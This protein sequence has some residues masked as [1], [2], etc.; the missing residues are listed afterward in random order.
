MNTRA[1]ADMPFY[2]GPDRTLFGLF[3]AC[4]TPARKAVLLCPPLGQDLIRCH[5]L[6][7][8]LAQALAAEGV[9]AL[10]FDYYGTGDSAGNS[11]DMDW[12]RC[13]ADTAAAANEL[14]T[15]SG[16]D[17]VFAFGARLG[18]SIA[19]ASAAQA[20]F[21]GVVA[22]DPVLDGRAYVTRLDA[23]Q[24]ALCLDGQ[25]FMVPRNAADA[26]AQ[27]LGFAISDSFRQQVMDLHVDRPTVPTLLLDSLSSDA[28]QP[29]GSF[30][31]D[32]AAVKCVQP[33]TPWNDPRR[34]EVAILSH[35]LIQ[36]VTRHVQEA[37]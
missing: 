36:A 26:A 2:F 25:R 3:H 7:R 11:V 18:G 12:Q 23:M 34:L 6:Y 24:S 21:A 28:P 10:R 33:A 22:W 16:I 32:A 30:V 29:W 27:W 14:R 20:R 35:P 37:A 13:L 5:R 17:R 1:D 8:Q 19:L 4:G 15:R 9:A 31:A